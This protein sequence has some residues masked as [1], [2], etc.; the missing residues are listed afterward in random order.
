MKRIIGIFTVLVLLLVSVGITLAQGLDDPYTSPDGLIVSPPVGIEV[1]DDGFLSVFGE[2]ADGTSGIG[3]QAI[4]GEDFFGS[5]VDEIYDF[6]VEFFALSDS[7]TIVGDPRRVQINGTDAIIQE[8]DTD[9]FGRAVILIFVINDDFFGFG[10]GYGFVDADLL[11]EVARSVQ[12]DPLLSIREELDFD[13]DLDNFEN[14]D[15]D[16]IPQGRFTLEEMPEGTIY[17]YNFEGGS[18]F[19]YNAA[20]WEPYIDQR[21]VDSTITLLYEGDFSNSVSITDNGR[22]VFGDS[23]TA[24]YVDF[25]IPML[26][27]LAGHED[28]NAEEHIMEVELDDDGR[29]ALVYDSALYVE[30]GSSLFAVIVYL[31]PLQENHIGYIQA[32]ISNQGELEAIRADIYEMAATFALREFVLEGV[33]NDLLES[34]GINARDVINLSCSAS[35]FGIIDEGTPSAVVLCPAGCDLGSVWGTDIYTDDSSICTAAVHSGAITLDGGLIRVEYT[36]GQESYEGTER[37]GV[38]TSDWGSWGGSFIV[39]PVTE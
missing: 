34:L 30:S 8:L 5:S 23:G 16:A 38:R 10:L 31:V 14:F 28:F 6:I 4:E 25:I 7:E 29:V 3:I 15:P 33:D 21:Y 37:N 13:F 36:E 20:L 26:T 19:N 9:E 2:T 18:E 27:G 32:L 17:L 12:I 24:L 35:T 1:E 11:V 22:D 39:V